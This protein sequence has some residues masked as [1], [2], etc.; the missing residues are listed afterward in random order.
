MLALVLA[1]ILAAV[2]VEKVVAVVNGVPVLAT[3]VEL[4]QIAGLVPAHADEDAAGHERV[5]V[6]A[7][8]DLELRWQD[9]RAA[10]ITERT[11]VDVDAAWER[12]AE[13]AGGEGA[14]TQRLEAAGLSPAA[15][16]FLLRRASVVQAYVAERFEPFVRPTEAEIESAWKE[17]LAPELRASGRPVPELDAVRDRVEVLV[18]EE[19]L[20]AEIDRWTS[21]LARRAEIV[22]YR[23]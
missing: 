4:A 10:S 1:A 7:L 16:R 17:R 13:R 8:I 3:D 9:L 19:K 22:R 12:V 11:E 2:P 5:V 21:E 14:L 23:R 18:R 15:L 20:L 6:D